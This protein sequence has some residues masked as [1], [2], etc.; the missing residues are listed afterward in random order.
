MPVSIDEIRKASEEF[1][2]L[3]DMARNRLDLNTEVGQTIDKI[4]TPI[5]RKYGYLDTRAGMIN[6]HLEHIN[7]NDVEIFSKTPEEILNIF[8]INKEDAF[9]AGDI[10]FNIIHRYTQITEELKKLSKL[11]LGD[12]AYGVSKEAWHVYGILAHISNL[13]KM[14]N[15]VN[16]TKTSET[17]EKQKEIAETLQKELYYKRKDITESIKIVAEKYNMSAENIIAAFKN[18]LG[19]TPEEYSEAIINEAFGDYVQSKFSQFGNKVASKLGGQTSVIAQ[20]K[21]DAQ[22][23]AEVLL[24]DWN[25]TTLG[26]QV[27]ATPVALTS[28]LVNNRHLAQT[29]AAKV[30]KKYK[31][32]FVKTGTSSYLPA[33]FLRNFFYD[34]I[35][36]DKTKTLVPE[37]PV[38]PAGA[39]TTAPKQPAGNPTQATPNT[40]PPTASVKTQAMDADSIRNA[41]EKLPANQRVSAILGSLPSLSDDDI[42]KILTALVTK[43]K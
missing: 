29:L 18:I 17:F 5:Y 30:V 14:I 35:Y 36:A 25:M 9:R 34:I 16:H 26:K 41:I 31:P 22:R 15:D 27:A 12:I 10:D 43:G 40:P 11:F 3:L 13:A 38:T 28:Y 8:G 1:N 32:S 42:K 39:R 33:K 20:A 24:R 2:K 4:I 7:P 6:I 19:A 23:G 21:L 37:K